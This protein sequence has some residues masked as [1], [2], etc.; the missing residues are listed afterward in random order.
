MSDQATDAVPE[1]EDG[2]WLAYYSDS[3]A[4]VPFASELEA[5]RHA[6]SYSMSVRFVR[7]G[8]ADWHTRA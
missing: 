3:S 8:D 6:I 7:F 1:S 2:V 5:L 4:V